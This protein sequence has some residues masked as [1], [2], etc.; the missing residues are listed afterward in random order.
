MDSHGQNEAANG[1]RF[2]GNG[3][4]NHHGDGR[5]KHS[6]RT[7]FARNFFS[8]P[9]M[10]GSIIPS[11]RYLVRRLLDQVNWEAARTIVEFGPGVGNITAEILARLQPAGRVIAFETN[12]DFVKHLRREFKDD[13]L[14]VAPTSAEN[15][16]T[17]LDQ[18][19]VG[20]ADHVISG[21]PF[22]VMP[23]NVRRSI[24]EQTRNS[25]RPGGS[26]LVYQFSSAVKPVLANVFADVKH[27]FEWFNVLPA[28]VFCCS[29]GRNGASRN[30]AGSHS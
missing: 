16:R 23:E 12:P 5:S 22:S 1:S 15:L 4:N 19:A 7:L 27:E 14:T 24:V 6:G 26:M 11:S 9:L 30:G 29:H 17:I 18:H 21:I 10:L 2:S 8:H 3:R 13:R 20:A 28:H 25:L